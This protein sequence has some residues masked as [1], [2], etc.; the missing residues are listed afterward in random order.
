MDQDNDITIPM[1]MNYMVSMEGRMMGKMN[2]G[3][4]KVD[5]RFE[6]VDRRFDDVD[7]RLNL[8][9]VQI[10]NIDERLD[11]VEVVQLPK[12]KKAIGIK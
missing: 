9:S 6:E 12:I 7:R 1:I 2:E 4:A 5:R 3:F 8:I 11:D 10:G